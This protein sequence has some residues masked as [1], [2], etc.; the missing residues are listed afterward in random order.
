[1]LEFHNAVTY[2]RRHSYFQS[3]C[4][5]KPLQ[6]DEQNPFIQTFTICFPGAD[7]CCWRTNV[8]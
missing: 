2:D 5:A 6:V 4:T 1:M 7:F 8:F 3:L